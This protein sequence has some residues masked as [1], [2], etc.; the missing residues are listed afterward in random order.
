MNAPDGMVLMSYG[1]AEALGY[2]GIL[3]PVEGVVYT[4]GSHRECMEELQTL[5]ATASSKS[6]DK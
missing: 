1:L 2:Y 6:E 4:Y 5:L 3:H